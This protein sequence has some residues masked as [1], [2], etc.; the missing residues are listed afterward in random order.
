MKFFSKMLLLCACVALVNAAALNAHNAGLRSAWRASVGTVQGKLAGIGQGVLAGTLGLL[1]LTAPLTAIEAH[2]EATRGTVLQTNS[3]LQEEIS[4]LTLEEASFLASMITGSNLVW[5][6]QHVN[7]FWNGDR[8]HASKFT[9]SSAVSDFARIGRTIDTVAERLYTS[10]RDKVTE[11]F[12]INGQLYFQ[13][14]QQLNPIS[15][16][17]LP[18]LPKIDDS[19]KATMAFSLG[20]LKAWTEA[21]QQKIRR[22]EQQK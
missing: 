16:K 22:V 8:S 2:D 12:Y 14:E 6:G 7:R 13:T 19:S 1:L 11:L 17:K 9:Y 4:G 18:P 21:A 15:A 20:K 10:D 3:E 5:V